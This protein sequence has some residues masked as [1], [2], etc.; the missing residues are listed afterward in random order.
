MTIPTTDRE[1]LLSNYRFDLVLA[2]GR[3][4]SRV[5]EVRYGINTY[6]MLGD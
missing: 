6:R 2:V 3:A 5:D 1:L 4:A